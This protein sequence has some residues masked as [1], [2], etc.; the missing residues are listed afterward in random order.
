LTFVEP[1]F[2][3]P[4]FKCPYGEIYPKIR[5][6]LVQK[7]VL[8]SKKL[9]VAEQC[10]TNY[11]DAFVKTRNIQLGLGA[12]PNQ[13]YV[14]H[15]RKRVV[16]EADALDQNEEHA[17]MCPH[18]GRQKLY[19][20]S[21]ATSVC[22]NSVC[23]QY[24]IV[25]SISL[26]AQQPKPYKMER[27]FT[28]FPG[29]SKR[30][31]KTQDS[32]PAKRRSRNMTAYKRPTHWKD[33]IQRA[34]G[35]Q[36][37]VIDDYVFEVIFQ[38]LKM[39]RIEDVSSVSQQD[40]YE[41]L[42]KNSLTK[43]YVHYI[44]IHWELTGIQPWQLTEDEEHELYDSFETVQK[45]FDECRSDRTSMWSYPYMG[46]KR[47]EMLANEDADPEQAY[48]W[49]RAQGIFHLLKGDGR[50]ADLDEAWRK[51]CALAGWTF[52]PTHNFY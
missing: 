5:G 10:P 46:H 43:W 12:V 31:R 22:D 40:V 36:S 24:G 30:R 14:P 3:P 32:P 7:M 17:S 42:K 9:R 19:N 20:R 1:D 21:S 6:Q 18:C 35:K 8:M 39:E 47:C 16:N 48:R 25:T 26:E 52:Y 27:M 50:L 38:H 51:F 44:K 37:T 15:K 29:G 34:Q 2:T 45:Y 33:V 41:I 13:D 49:R 4:V 28:R 11:M 23:P